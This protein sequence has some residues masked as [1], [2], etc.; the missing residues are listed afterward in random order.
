MIVWL[1][2]SLSNHYFSGLLFV[3]FL[4]YAGC[5]SN[6]CEN[7]GTCTDDVNNYQCECIEGYTGV[8]CETGEIVDAI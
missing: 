6:P 5:Q 1:S 2:F 4:D 8:N 3:L 7:N